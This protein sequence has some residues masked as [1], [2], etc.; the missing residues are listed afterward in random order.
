MFITIDIIKN[1][2]YTLI[3]SNPTIFALAI[4]D[5]FVKVKKS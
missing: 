4:A 2:I 3:H 1:T 5:N